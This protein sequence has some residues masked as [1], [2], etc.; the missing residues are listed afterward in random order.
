MYS[1]VA[2]LE[3]LT[4]TARY[5]ASMCFYTDGSLIDGCARFAFHRNGEVGFGYKISSPGGFFTVE[6]TVLFVTL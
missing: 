3:L 2:P 4:V 6:L 5:A 1:V